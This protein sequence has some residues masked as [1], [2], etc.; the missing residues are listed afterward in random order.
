M[1]RKI[2]G[3]YHTKEAPYLVQDQHITPTAFKD[4]LT[5]NL[6]KMT[7]EGRLNQ[8]LAFQQRRFKNKHPSYEMSVFRLNESIPQH[9]R[10]AERCV[11][12]QVL[13]CARA[14]MCVRLENGELQ[15]NFRQIIILVKTR[16]RLYIL[17]YTTVH[18]CFCAK[19][20]YN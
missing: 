9:L 17:P 4:Q 16:K 15:K 13:S 12:K 20:N 18:R 6:Y 7:P 11:N 8:I 3:R 2:S 19:I 10:T 14:R 5:I 1:P